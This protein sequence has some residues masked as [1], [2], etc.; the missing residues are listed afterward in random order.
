ML[1]SLTDWLA[2]HQQW[3]GIAIFLVSLTESLA[4]A[5]LVVPGVFLLFAIS[6]L[7]ASAGVSLT[8][9]VIW[10]FAGA[11]LGDL[12]SFALGRWFHQD[13]RRLPLFRRNPQWIDQGERFFRRYGWL[14]VVL[15]RFIGPLRPI[16]PMIAGMFD[17]PAWRFIAINVLSA[18]AWAPAYLIPGYTAGQ[19]ASWAV[20]PLFWGQALNLAAGAAIVLGGSLYLLRWQ[21]RWSP[22]AAAGLCLLALLVLILQQHTL[23]VF[24]ATLVASREHLQ[25]PGLPA[26]AR[27]QPEVLLLALPIPLSLLLARQWGACWLLLLALTLTLALSWLAGLSTASS[28]AALIT[29]ML[30]VSIVLCNRGQG[31]WTRVS[32]L[33]YPLP[34]LALL[35]SNLL[36]Q[37]VADPMA[38][39]S[40]LLCASS[41]VLLSSW[42][43]QRASPL[44]P[45]PPL[46][47]LLVASWPY[48][49]ACW[50]LLKAP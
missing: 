13:I 11:V 15:G 41:A 12:L 40:S 37:Q 7:A 26:L 25:L 28:I 36:L 6:A 33:L 38:L 24:S 3:L 4:V 19:A 10:A 9:A 31:F 29:A 30:G 49:I 32:W 34:L 23:D 16:I 18:L 22:L 43:V 47:R 39:L 1:S 48:L 14:S 45:M 21:R 2:S 50:L 20:P 35:D 27:P 46:A 42:L 44:A 8:E 5:G 17:M